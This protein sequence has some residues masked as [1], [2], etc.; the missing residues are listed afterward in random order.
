MDIT[1]IDE[2]EILI[3]YD[4]PIDNTKKTICHLDSIIYRDYLS[5]LRDS[6]VLI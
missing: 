5:L 6:S 4:G 1:L 2:I 3:I